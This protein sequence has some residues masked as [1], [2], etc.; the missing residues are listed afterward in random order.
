MESLDASEKREQRHAQRREECMD[1][2]GGHEARCLEA[3]TIA[4][5]RSETGTG[6][7]VPL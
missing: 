7:E 6:L 3:A 5:G 2:A 4:V 1:S